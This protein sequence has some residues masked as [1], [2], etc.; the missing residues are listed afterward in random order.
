MYIIN[1]TFTTSTSPTSVISVISLQ[2]K[3]CHTDLEIANF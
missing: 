1:N 2:Q 3:H